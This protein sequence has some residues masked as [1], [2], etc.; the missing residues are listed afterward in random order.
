[1]SIVDVE[2][3]DRIL[4]IGSNIRKEQPLLA[5]RIRQ[6]TKINHALL[7]FINPINS[8][9]LVPTA[10]DYLV[11]PSRMKGLLLQVVKA[12]CLALGRPFADTLADISVEADAK[13]IAQLLVS[14]QQK[15]ILVGSVARHHPDRSKIEQISHLLGELVGA[16]VGL[17]SY[18]PNSLGA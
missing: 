5:H 14:G 9:S 11:A 6:A 13:E 7:A 16:K 15:L 2:S 18:G 10:K 3:L 12:V 4:V 17:L 1:M 8:D